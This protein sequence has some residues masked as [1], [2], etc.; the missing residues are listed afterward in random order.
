MCKPALN[1]SLKPFCV[2][3]VNQMYLSWF[4]DFDIQKYIEYAR[5][6]VGISDL[7][8][9]VSQTQNNPNI[10]FFRVFASHTGEAPKWVGTVK[11]EVVDSKVAEIGIMIGRHSFRGRGVGRFAIKQ[12]VEYVCANYPTLEKFIAGVAYSNTASLNLFTSLGF[13][14]EETRRKGFVLPD[15]NL[16][17]EVTLERLVIEK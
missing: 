9:Y 16:D 3:H 11:C 14:I 1:V 15:G 7:K 4:S 12:C 8:E 5:D 17:D 13:Q 10:H 6:N 2:E